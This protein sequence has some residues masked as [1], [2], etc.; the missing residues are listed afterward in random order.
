MT[1]NE[2]TNSL[3]EYFLSATAGKTFRNRSVNA[4]YRYDSCRCR[5]HVVWYG[6]FSY[7]RIIF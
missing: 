3:P 6:S 7:A 4:R 2:S 5:A 1:M